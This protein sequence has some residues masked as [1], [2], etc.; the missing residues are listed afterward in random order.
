M[1]DPDALEILDF[2]WRAGPDRWFGGGAAF[3]ADCATFTALHERAA[4]GD[5]DGWAAEPAGA[6]AR[7]ILLDQLPRNLFRGTPRA[8]ATDAAALAAAEAALGH[9]FDRAYPTAARPFFYLPFMHA[10]DLAAQDR[11]LD[12]FRILGERENYHYALLHHDPVRRFG[13]FPHRNAILGRP[14]SPE[15]DAYLASGGFSG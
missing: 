6:L 1:T 14:S 7:I 10:E 5:C 13:R 2:W 3:D 12:L 11:S 4:A 8:F 15:E 9:G